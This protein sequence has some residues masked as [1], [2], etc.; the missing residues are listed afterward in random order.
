MYIADLRIVHK[1]YMYII[2]MYQRD[3][4]RGEGV[5][6][7]WV[8]VGVALVWVVSFLAQGLASS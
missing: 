7:P 3:L 5:R 1:V 8:L 4:C 2:I 6:W